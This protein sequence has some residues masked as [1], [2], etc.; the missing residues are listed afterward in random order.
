MSKKLYEIR[1]SV[2]Y[3]VVVAAETEAQAMEHVESWEHSWDAQ[4]DLLGAEMELVDIREPKSAE[5]IEDEAHVI[6][7]E[8]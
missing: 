1:A 2:E 8:A 5:T 3:A 7:E 4:A 6:L